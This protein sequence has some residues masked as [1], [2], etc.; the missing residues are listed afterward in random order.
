MRPIAGGPPLAV[1]RLSPTALPYSFV[2]TE[3]D[4]MMQGTDFSGPVEVTARLDQD[5]DPLTRQPGDWMGTL[6]TSIGDQKVNIVIDQ[7]AE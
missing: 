4:Q 2:I 5:G 6:K 7:P 3:A 1:R